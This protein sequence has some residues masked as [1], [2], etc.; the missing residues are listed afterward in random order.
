ME[1]S[2]ER[3]NPYNE[4]DEELDAILSGMTEHFCIKNMAVVILA[5]VA[6]GGELFGHAV[7]LRQRADAGVMLGRIP[8]NG[9]RFVMSKEV[10]FGFYSPV[11]SPPP[12]TKP[13]LQKDGARKGKSRH[14][15]ASSSSHWD[16]DGFKLAGE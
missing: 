14:M 2:N 15:S 13:Y 12:Q 4:T 6:V 5:K 10:F 11:G 3:P 1:T 16:G 9:H 8:W 7:S